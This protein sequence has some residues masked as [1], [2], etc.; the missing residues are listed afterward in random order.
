MTTL[1]PNQPNSDRWLTYDK[2]DLSKMSL[3]LLPLESQLTLRGLNVGVEVVFAE[4]MAK[5]SIGNSKAILRELQEFTSLLLQNFFIQ[6]K[7]KEQT[8]KEVLNIG[9]QNPPEEQL[10]DLKDSYGL[11]EMYWGRNPDGEA[12]L[13]LKLEKEQDWLPYD[14][15][16][17]QDLLAMSDRNRH[18]KLPGASKGIGEYQFLYKLGWKVISDP[19]TN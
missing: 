4:A 6:A 19:T 5:I 15:D 3:D 16:K 11:G 18:Q 13:M 12:V 17:W 14:N 2:E 7:L 10:V 9:H 8:T 1:D